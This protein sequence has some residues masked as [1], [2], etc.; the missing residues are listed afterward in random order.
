MRNTDLN[1]IIIDELSVIDDHPVSDIIYGGHVVAVESRKIGIATWA[2][3]LHPIPEKQLDEIVSPY[4][5]SNQ[6]TAELSRLM[7]DPDPL[8]VSLGVAALNSLLPDPP[9]K[10]LKDINAKDLILD[11]GKGKHVVVVGHFPFVEKMGDQFSRFSVLEKNPKGGDINAIHSPDI[12]PEADLVAI[13]ATTI[14]N[15]TLPGILEQIRPQAIKILVG[16][17]TPL[18]QSLFH[19]GFDF[20]AGSIVENRQLAIDGIVSGCSFKDIKGVRHVV[21][22]K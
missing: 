1:N 16:P 17:S 12:L 9:E 18:C 19:V 8:K 6:S 7:L 3:P 21:W 10:E 22:A 2:S 13:T 20:L 5:E 11:Y 14:S 4:M 15:H